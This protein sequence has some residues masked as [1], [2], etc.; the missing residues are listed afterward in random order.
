MHKKDVRKLPSHP[1]RAVKKYDFIYT[2]GIKM[3]TAPK[4]TIVIVI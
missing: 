4:R 2:G 1:F 3:Y